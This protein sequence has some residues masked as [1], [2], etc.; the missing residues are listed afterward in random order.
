[1][2]AA[3]GDQQGSCKSAEK[4]E[5]YPHRTA[6]KESAIEESAS[7]YNRA[8]VAFVEGGNNRRNQDSHEVQEHP[9]LNFSL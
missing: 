8:G 6:G 9:E 1:M 4:A 7:T 2:K 5:E 3:A